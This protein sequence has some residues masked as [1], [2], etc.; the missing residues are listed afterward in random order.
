MKIRVGPLS[1]T[2]YKAW[3]RNVNQYL[4][5]R[6][7]YISRAPY[8][9]RG[10]D[11][12][13][14][15]QDA[16]M[17]RVAWPE[18]LEALRNWVETHYSIAGVECQMVNADRTV[19]G[20]ADLVLVDTDEEFLILADVKTGRPWPDHELQIR[21]YATAFEA[22]A[23]NCG[24]LLYLSRSGPPR[25]RWVFWTPSDLDHIRQIAAETRYE[26][27]TQQIPDSVVIPVHGTTFVEADSLASA[28]EGLE[29][30]LE[31]EWVETEE[32]PKWGLRVKLPDGR[33]V[34]W[35]PDSIKTRI[36]PATATVFASRPTSSSRNGYVRVEVSSEY[37]DWSGIAVP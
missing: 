13:K 1:F 22:L 31:Q 2:A 9:H 11:I 4:L 16:A 28:T 33:P 8:L 3:K 20:R 5:Y 10:I 27:T 24:L 6:L 32:G 23:P 15:I 34:G 12:H 30:Y 37:I 21:W 17:G 19:Y 7:G 29:V 26:I 14:A 35:I 25:S 18:Q 36:Q